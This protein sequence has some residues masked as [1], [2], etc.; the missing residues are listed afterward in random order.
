YAD[1][2]NAQALVG[3][4]L[5]SI[6]PAH[7]SRIGRGD[8]FALNAYVEMN[9]ENDAPLQA[10]RHAVRARHQVATTLG[11]GP[12]FLHSTGQLH[13]GGSN[14]GVFLQI[15][16]DDATDLAIP[17]AQYSFGVLKDAQAQG[18]FDVLAERNRRALRVHLGADVRAGLDRLANLVGRAL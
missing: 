12:R 10:L 6:L 14:R 18:D 5:E 9:D 15:T 7:L 1:E 13:K 17:G 3:S 16:A 4:D 8:Y 2:R 11:Y